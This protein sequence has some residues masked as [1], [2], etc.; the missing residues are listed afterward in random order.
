MKLSFVFFQN[1]LSLPPGHGLSYILVG[2]LSTVCL[3][4]PRTDLAQPGGMVGQPHMFKGT[5]KLLF[6]LNNMC[7]IT[8]A[9]LSSGL[10]RFLVFQCF[11][12]LLTKL[13]HD[14]EVSNRQLSTSAAWTLGPEDNF[15]AFLFIF[16]FNQF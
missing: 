10:E 6:S 11:S 7:D 15:P 12:R 5:E 1:V 2:L 16:Q 4:S 13:C 14:K 9:N 3:Q 8:E